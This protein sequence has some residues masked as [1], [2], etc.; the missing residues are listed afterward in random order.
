MGELPNGWIQ[1]VETSIRNKNGKYYLNNYRP[2]KITNIVYKIR[3]T[4]ITN[5]LKPY[6]DFLTNEFKDAYK[7]GRWASDVLYDAWGNQKWGN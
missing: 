3:E 7:V 4:S 6:M 1:E 5:K 2:I